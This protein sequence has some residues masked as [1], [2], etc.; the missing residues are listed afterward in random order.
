MVVLLRRARVGLKRGVLMPSMPPFASLASPV[1]AAIYIRVSTPEQASE[2]YSLAMQE[3]TLRAYCASKGYSVVHVYQDAGLSA[4]DIVGRPALQRLL[5]DSRRG[6]FDVVLVWKLSRFTRSLSD[7]CRACDEME[8]SGCYLESYS[9]AFDA[10]TTVGRMIRGILGV[11]AQWEREVIS[12]NVCAAMQERAREGKPTTFCVLGYDYATPNTLMINPQ[13]A[14]IVKYIYAAYLECESIM[15]TA[16]LCQSLQYRGKRGGRLAC[17][18][19]EQIL[20]RP[21]Y[22]GFCCWHDVPFPG[23]HPPII[24]MDTYNDVQK[25]ILRV[26]A[27]AGRRRKYPLYLLSAEGAMTLE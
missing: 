10:H 18:S 21:I 24:P 20:T 15:R 1:R 8:Q 25:M 16:E 6:L 2:G 3:S 11:I 13:E 19:V 22:A 14:R 7:L 12:E 9:E 23:Q 26:G 17:W 4:K 27:R 5:A